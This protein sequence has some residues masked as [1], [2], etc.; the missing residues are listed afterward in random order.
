MVMG[1]G[2]VPVILTTTGLIVGT[3]PPERAGSASAISETSADSAVRW[4]SPSRQ[5][6]HALLQVR[7]AGRRPDGPLCRRQTSVTSALGTALEVAPTPATKPPRGLMLRRQATPRASR[8]CCA[9]ATITLL[10]L[11]AIGARVYARTEIDLDA[12]AGSH[13]H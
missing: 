2:F 8:L 7:H 5:P 3:A 4:A 11:A 13:D 9:L 10:L 6:R 12:A 1:L